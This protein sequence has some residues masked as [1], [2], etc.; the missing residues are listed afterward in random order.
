MKS[1]WLNVYHVIACTM[2]ILFI[3]KLLFDLYTGYVFYLE[4]TGCDGAFECEQQDDG[5]LKCVKIVG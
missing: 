1:K 5:T 4:Q 3:V 2:M